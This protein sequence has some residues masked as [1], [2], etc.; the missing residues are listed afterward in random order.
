MKAN[1]HTYVIKDNGQ[2]EEQGIA[3]DAEGKP[4][5]EAE[6]D[7]LPADEKDKL[8]FNQAY[9]VARGNNTEVDFKDPEFWDKV[10][11]PRMGEKLLRSL[12]VA[13]WARGHG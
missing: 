7:K 4:L 13:V 1:S 12:D 8:R 6:K 11:G 5:S 9:F 3:A 2:G 10:L